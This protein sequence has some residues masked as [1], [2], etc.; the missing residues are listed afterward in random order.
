MTVRVAPF[1][2]DPIS[3]FE[4]HASRVT[5]ARQTKENGATS[6]F[7]DMSR[8]TLLENERRVVR[9]RLHVGSKMVRKKTYSDI[10]LNVYVR[11]TSWKAGEGGVGRS[12][13]STYAR[14][15]YMSMCVL[16]IRTYNYA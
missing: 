10:I 9:R 8:K 14:V 16:R 11:I 7:Q 6:I 4:F 5:I 3:R 2:R 15:T 1:Q 12:Y 13:I